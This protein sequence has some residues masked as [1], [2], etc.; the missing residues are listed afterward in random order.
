[1]VSSSCSTTIRVLPRS[2]RPL[3]GGQQLVVVPLVQADGRLVQ[4]I[5]HPHEAA[6]D[7]GGQADAL[8]LAAGQG[9]AGRG[10]GSGSSGPRTAGSPAGSGSPSRIWAAMSC[11]VS[12]RVRVLKNASSRS[13]G[14]SVASIMDRSPTVTARASGRRRRPLQAGQGHWVMNSS[15]SRLLASDWVS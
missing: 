15:I 12:V 6:A 8:A 3:Q 10:T 2:R 4:D 9:A 1:M 14:S 5:Q 7:L 11:C 13:T